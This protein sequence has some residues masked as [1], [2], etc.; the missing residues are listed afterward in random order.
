MHLVWDGDY[1]VSALSVDML[2]SSFIWPNVLPPDGVIV[3]E[4]TTIARDAVAQSNLHPKTCLLYPFDAA[5]HLTRLDSGGRLTLTEQC[6][7]V[8][9][10]CI[11]HYNTVFRL[12]DIS[13]NDTNLV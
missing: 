10:K 11:L 12:T 7:L 1:V 13:V 3:D 9:Y 5:D 6:R 8:T 2:G 4:A